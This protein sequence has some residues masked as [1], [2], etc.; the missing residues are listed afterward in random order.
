MVLFAPGEQLHILHQKVRQVQIT[1]YSQGPK[2]LLYGD[3]A[4]LIA[5]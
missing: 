2:H 3:C 1:E 5:K 4:L